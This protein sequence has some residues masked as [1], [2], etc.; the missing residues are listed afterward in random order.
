MQYKKI[1]D[2]DNYTCYFCTDSSTTCILHPNLDQLDQVFTNV[3]YRCKT[4]IL[5]GLMAKLQVFF[6]FMGKL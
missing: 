1:R 5:F 2:R 6:G 3:Y 4:Q